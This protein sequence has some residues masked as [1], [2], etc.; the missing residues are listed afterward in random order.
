M[1]TEALK[2]PAWFS[3]E[4][5]EKP[6]LGRA[7]YTTR[8]YPIFYLMILKCGCTFLRNLFYHLDHGHLHADAGRIH[9]HDQDFLKAAHVPHDVIQ[10][11]PYVFTVVRDPVDRFLSLYFDKIANTEN[12]VD[13][14]MRRRIAEG[15]GLELGP[16]ISIT[17]HRENCLKMLGWLKRNLDDGLEGRTNPHW[18]RQSVSIERIARFKPTLIPLPQVQDRLDALLGP[19][20]PDIGKH[21]KAITV[22]NVSPKL[23]ERSVFVTDE[24]VE[25][26]RSIYSKDMVLF[27][28]ARANQSGIS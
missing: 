15:A 20:V 24:L 26:T 14:W 27:E 13:A 6:G 16:E 11:S 17:T 23:F 4:P 22:R 18:Q 10:S 28:I 12:E 25:M 8:T 7:L 19:I 9:A 2:L 5:S 21:M 1:T 3:G